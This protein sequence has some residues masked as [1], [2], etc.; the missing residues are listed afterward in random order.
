MTA[1]VFVGTMYCGEGDFNRC[2]TAIQSQKGVTV[3]HSVVS[4]LSEK[5]AHNELWRRWRAVQHTFDMFVKVDADTV[6]AH[7]EVLLE[8][9]TLMQSN[10]RITGI[11]APLLDYFT[12]NYINGLNCFSPKVVFRETTDHLYCDR[13]DTN[14]DVVV[15]SQDVPQKLRPAGYHCYNPTTQQAFH[16][17]L[18]RAL[19]NQTQVLKLVNEAWRRKGDDLRAWALLGAQCAGTFSNGEF[20]YTDERFSA[21]YE[22]VRHKFDELR[23]R[24]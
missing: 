22:S 13:V 3:E 15:K 11:Q 9:W 1:R 14:H 23:G 12:D 24:L 19:K 4:G 16:F 8:F 20:N 5:E 6:L 18:H 10:E 21:A 7:D 17:G 2:C